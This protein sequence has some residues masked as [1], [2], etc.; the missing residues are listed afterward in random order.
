MGGEP[1]PWRLSVF[2]N[3]MRVRDNR[4]ADLFTEPIDFPTVMIFGQ[5]DEYYDYARKKQPAMYVDPVI[6]EHGEGHKFPTGPGHQ[7]IFEEVSLQ[8]KSIDLANNHASH[9]HS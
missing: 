5:K 7:E 9:K 3:G 8:T 6:L 4:Y 1:I 2:F